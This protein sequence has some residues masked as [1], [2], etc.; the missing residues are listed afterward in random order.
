MDV[1]Q[2]TFA[3]NKASNSASALFIP[4][5]TAIVKDSVFNTNGVDNSYGAVA[6]VTDNAN[7]TLDGCT[8]SN[9]YAVYH[10]G[11]IWIEVEAIL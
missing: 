1:Q 9:N 10:S 3:D 4:S 8:I 6:R 2:C 5:G 7:L 11:T